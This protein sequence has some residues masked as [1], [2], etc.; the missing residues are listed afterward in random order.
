MVIYFFIL[1]FIR[2]F[3]TSFQIE[4]CFVTVVTLC[5]IFIQDLNDLALI[6]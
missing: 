1:F 5:D 4:K 3:K 2:F 6:F